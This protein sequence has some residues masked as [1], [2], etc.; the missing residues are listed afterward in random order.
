MA[1]IDELA[2]LL[3]SGAATSVGLT[4]AALSEADADV[5]GAF[6]AVTG[7]MALEDAES[8]DRELAAG[9]DRG[10]LHGVPVAVKD[11]IDVAGVPT[12]NGAPGFADRTPQAH[13]TVWR[14]LRDAG[15]VLV[16]KTRLP[17]LALDLRTPGCANPRDPTRTCGG[18]SGGSAAA[19]AAGI[20]PVAL[21]TDT[22]G[23]V[24]VPAALTGTAGLRPT[25]RTLPYD[26][27]SPLSPSQDTVGILANTPGDCLLALDVMRVGAGLKPL[28]SAVVSGRL[29]IGV[30]ELWRGE[31]DADIACA[32]GALCER[33][34][35]G[36]YVRRCRLDLASLSPAVS[37]L[38]TTY[39]A[40]RLWPADPAGAVLPPSVLHDLAFGA[41]VP[42]A[43]YRE[44]R[45]LA[46]RI[47]S[48]LRLMF[49]VEADVIAL[50]TTATTAVP[51]DTEQVRCGSERSASV[52]SAYGRFTALASVSGLPAITVPCGADTAGLPIGVQLIGPPDSEPVLCWLAAHVA[53]LGDR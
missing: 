12:R 19:V 50:P 24:R 44:A 40:A 21:G 36:H 18:S 48:A 47:S 35:S 11:V 31:V 34:A 29:R 10:A 30:P 27:V 16:G 8:A 15:A 38:L 49:A 46:G 17:A 25:Y 9:R 39:E 51:F 3:R 7:D 28:G 6:V 26:G 32:F 5:Y 37:Y 2:D 43:E 45:S 41:D 33:L 13:A 42:E 23:S 14:A 20:V 53:G 4:E 52:S 22:S 1:R